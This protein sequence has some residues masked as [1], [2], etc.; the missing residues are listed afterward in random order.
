MAAR[1]GLT[2][3]DTFAGTHDLVSS[4]SSGGEVHGQ[5]PCTVVGVLAASGSVLD[6]LIVTSSESVWT[7]HETDTALDGENHKILEQEREVTLA[8][9]R[10]K[11]LLA[12]VTFARFINT[13][14]KMQAAASA[15]EI[16]HL[17][18]LIGVGTNVR[19]ALASVLLLT[20]APVFL[21]PCGAPCGSAAPAWHCCACW[22]RHRGA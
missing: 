19:N 9:I 2:S 10:Y 15:L 14:T 12:A 5:T 22:A 21:L 6:R 18:S 1:K 16:T 8:L 3:G 13:T 20:A 7:L 17:L 11:T 4:A